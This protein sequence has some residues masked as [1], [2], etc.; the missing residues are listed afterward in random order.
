MPPLPLPMSPGKMTPS[1]HRGP[2][3]GHPAAGAALWVRVHHPSEK[4][5]PAPRG[6]FSMKET[7]IDAKIHLTR[8]L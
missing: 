5:G 6:C 4:E 3:R 8:M 2:S 1:H 7:R